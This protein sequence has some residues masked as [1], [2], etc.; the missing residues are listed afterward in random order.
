MIDLENNQVIVHDKDGNSEV[1]MIEKF[2][3]WFQTPFGL[4]S[5]LNTAIAKVKSEDYPIATIRCVPVAIA[6]AGDYYEIINS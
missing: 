3:V 6:D 1:M 2:E 4:T 5:N